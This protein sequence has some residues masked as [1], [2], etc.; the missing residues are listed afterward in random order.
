MRPEFNSHKTT[1]PV[2]HRIIPH[3][4]LTEFENLWMFFRYFQSNSPESANRHSYRI[5]TVP[6]TVPGSVLAS[7][8]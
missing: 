1:S 7:T 8:F 2:P 6:G 4:T 3:G 5:G